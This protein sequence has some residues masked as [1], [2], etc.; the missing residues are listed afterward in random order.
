MSVIRPLRDEDLTAVRD[1]YAHYVAETVATFDEVAPD[2]DAWT[3]KAGAV[4]AAG[5]PFLV[6]EA[7]GRVL[8]FAYAGQYRPKPAYRHT[9]EDT[10]YL[11]PGATGHG[12]G[13]RLLAALIEGCAATPARQMV[14]MIADT[15][16]A[17]SAKLHLRHGFTEAGRL[18]RVGFKLG[19]WV[20][21]VI[22]QRELAS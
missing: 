4:T 5:M 6:A 12:L 10:I 17:A 13:G 14:A 16:L 9:V 15:G 21:V 22:Y 8:G 11:A 20:D 2:L 7:D 19:R 18:T 1:I 3:A